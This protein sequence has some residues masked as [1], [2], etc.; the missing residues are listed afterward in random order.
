M[1][2]AAS[3][4]LVSSLVAAAAPPPRRTARRACRA[5]TP[6]GM[7]LSVRPQDDF[8][9]YVNGTWAD[10]TPIP[11]DARRLRHVR[12]PARARPGSGARHPRGRSDARRRRPARSAR[13]SAT[14]TRASWTRRASSRSASQPL[15]GEL[16]A[17]DGISDRQRPAGGV[18]ARR[19]H[20][21]AAALLG[22]RRR[23]IRATPSLRRADLAG[24]PRA[25]PIATT[26]CGPTRSS[27]RSARRTRP[28]S[29]GSFTLAQ[30]ARSG[31]RRRAHPRARDRAREGS[32]GIAR[33]TAIATPPTTR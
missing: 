2:R 17:I 18:C 26:T 9:R 11:A 29:R 7:D 21:R 6:P 5:S 14:S 33:A 15:A 16:A 28:T 20:R 19:A 8:F 32:S 10:K 22:Q 24:G 13:R 30:S 4:L 3:L 1:K 27:P 31:R 23:R 25:C 12:D